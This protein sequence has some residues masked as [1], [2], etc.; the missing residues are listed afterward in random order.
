MSFIISLAKW[1]NLQV[2]AEGIETKDQVEL[3]KSLGCTYAQGFFYAKPMPTEQF[4]RQ[5][6]ESMLEARCTD[7]RCD[8][9]LSRGES[10]ESK[11]LVSVDRNDVDHPL[12]RE[13]YEGR[14]PVE[15]VRQLRQA[16]SLL[17]G[18]RTGVGAVVVSMPDS[19]S[20]AE[21]SELADACEK[22]AVPLLVI[23]D[24]DHPSAQEVM[25]LRIAD[26]LSR[27]FGVRQFDLR[28]R[29]AMAYA[30]LERFEQE[31]DVHAAIIEMRKRAERDALTGLLNRSEYGVRID[32]FFYLNDDP[33]GI[34]VVLDVDNF[35]GVNDAFG[36]VVGD[37]V[38][39]AVGDRIRYLFPETDTVARIGGDEFSFFVP[40]RLP[41]DQ[42]A[43]KMGKLCSRFQLSVENVEIS[44]SAG[45]C[46]CP[47]CGVSHKDL[48][49]NADVALIAAKRHG[50]S[51]FEIFQA[52]M[53]IPESLVFE[54]A[55]MQMLD[56]VSDALFVS[57]AITSEIVYI[58]EA[59]CR[60]IGKTRDICLGRRCYEL[61]WDQCHRCDR[62]EA[63]AQYH[64]V[65]FEERT[66]LKD[67]V[68]PVL[69]KARTE[70]WDG[71]GVKVHYLKFDNFGQGRVC[72]SS[73]VK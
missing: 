24:R 17:A 14:Y 55:T 32:Q 5:L 71:R 64:N 27:P 51:D 43:D 72:P 42:L 52:G 39:N 34:F 62:C 19:L 68:T 67:G 41:Y 63:V 23:D 58:N 3:L 48:Y 33:E 61:F 20:F 15:V 30:K 50:K 1:M 25:S 44:C 28:L 2:V 57:D 38:L 40:Y 60:V 35:K 13:E 12:L 22:R 4:G 49:R 59:A 11:M 53:E 73:E 29:N 69:I 9:S 36:H 47:E 66:V 54:Q 16:L 21:V 10:V 65:F 7:S 8:G 6:A 26:Y 18:E 31:K 45:V 70:Y 56:Q 46:Y 37:E